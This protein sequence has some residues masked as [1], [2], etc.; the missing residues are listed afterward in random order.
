MNQQPGENVLLAGEYYMFDNLSL[1]G[2]AFVKYQNCSTNLKV[3]MF[4]KPFKQSITTQY[5][6]YKEMST[7][8]PKNY[9]VFK[10]C[11]HSFN[12]TVIETELSVELYLPSEIPFYDF[13]CPSSSNELKLNSSKGYDIKTSGMYSIYELSYDTNFCVLN[14]TRATT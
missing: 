14:I 9:T 8:I 11:Y 2:F 13:S 4:H 7:W 12:G 5:N 1:N 6:I 3:L 10:Y